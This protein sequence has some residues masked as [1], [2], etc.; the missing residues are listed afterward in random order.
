MAACDR[1]AVRHL[2]VLALLVS[3]FLVAQMR[4][5]QPA[6]VPIVAAPSLVDRWLAPDVVIGGA[7][8]LLYAGEL[9]GDIRRLKADNK[10]MR[11][12]LHEDYMRRETIEARFAE[13]RAMVKR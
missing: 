6:P 11:R 8:V 9:R 13:I 1:P 12:M 5:Q 4:A 10:E 2:L 3:G 7:L